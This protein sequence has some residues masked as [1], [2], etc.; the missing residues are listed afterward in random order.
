MLKF[1]IILFLFL[2]SDCSQTKIEKSD[3]IKL[4]DEKNYVLDPNFKVGD[5]RRY[6]IYP[7]STSVN[8]RKHPNTGKYKIQT[9]IDFAEESQ[10]TINFPKGNYG[11]NLLIDSRENINFHFNK[12]GFSLI[13]ITNAK[14]KESKNINLR[15]ALIVYN[16]FGT[17]NSSNIILDTLILKSNP[18]KSLE[19]LRNKGCHIYKGTKNLK[20]EYLEV[21][22]LGSGSKD[23]R[24]NHAAL[25]IDGQG[26]NPVGINIKDVL[27]RSSDRHGVYITGSDHV[28]DNIVVEKYAQGDTEDMVGMQDATMDDALVL[29]G[30]WVNRCNNCNFKN[31][32]ISTK[33]SENG[34]PLKLDEGKVGM[35][36]IIENLE[37]DIKYQDSLIV[38]DVLTNVIV[39]KLKYKE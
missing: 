20:I 30:L 13:H 4:I 35:P 28:I 2:L 31:V 17:Y 5:A 8:N 38:D 34:F 10:T 36:T 7:D 24:T 33:Y 21:N 37:L 6:G 29:S 18:D 26:D 25:A 11:V 39:K 12:S 22:D 1:S 15:G 9:L 16:R 14:G 3:S 27:I 19:N 23:Y 32:K